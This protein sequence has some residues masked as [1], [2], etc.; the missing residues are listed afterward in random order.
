MLEMGMYEKAHELMLK[1]GIVSNYNID[2]NK[3]NNI[4]NQIKNGNQ[5]G[6][7]VMLQMYMQI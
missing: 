2:K 7:Y 6:Y 4:Y 5:N 1:S 3:L